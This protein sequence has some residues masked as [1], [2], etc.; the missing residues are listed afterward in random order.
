[1]KDRSNTNIGEGKNH[2][3]KSSLACDVWKCIDTNLGTCSVGKWSYGETR[4]FIEMQWR[5]F[6]CQA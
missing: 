4:W 2:P 1:M 6:M 5:A 3:M